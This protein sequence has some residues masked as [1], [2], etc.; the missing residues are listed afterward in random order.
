MQST[1]E[2]KVTVSGRVFRG[3]ENG[4]RIQWSITRISAN[5]DAK[6]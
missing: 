4:A 2:K 6:V 1:S 3:E 5:K